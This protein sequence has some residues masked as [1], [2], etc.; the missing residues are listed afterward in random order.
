MINTLIL[1][2]CIILGFITTIIIYNK[3]IDKSS[4]FINKYL[5]FLI[6]N[7][8]FYF[9]FHLIHSIDPSI[10]PYRILILA[11][12]TRLISIPFFYLY[13]EDL[14]FV[15]KFRKKKLLHFILPSIL[16]ILAISNSLATQKSLLVVKI[17]IISGMFF[18]LTYLT[19]A[20]ILLYKNVWFRKSDFKIVQEQNK[21][22]SNWT[23][24]LF[25]LFTSVFL[26]RLFM[27]TLY[28]DTIDYNQNIIWIPTLVWSF[29]FLKFILTPEIQYGYD[30]LN[31]NIKKITKQFVLPKIWETEKPIQ[32]IILT[33]D[34]K[35]AKK[36]NTT[37][38]EYIHQV[39]EASFHS[40]LFRNPNLTIDE[41]A[42]KLNIP[43]SHLN[44]VFKYHCHDSFS[45][46]KKIVRIH[47]AIKLLENNYL[48]TNTIESLSAEVGFVT[49][50]TFH[51]AFKSITG[52]TTQEYI[53]NLSIVK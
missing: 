24:F 15:E 18:V 11:D 8:C 21:L 7:T 42:T 36:I 19:M 51:V 34:I 25:I 10:L 43:S 37:L 41:M 31:K 39:E 44:F 50:N 26:F 40:H 46:Y 12:A 13:F 5:I 38:R 27:T 20:F 22:M 6:L 9:I 48:K 4:P 53:K 35:L 23:L 52:L 47:D 30:F 45:D 3:R 2:L 32:E 16:S 49:Y 14:V 1:F 29:I 28:Y 33:R 17:F